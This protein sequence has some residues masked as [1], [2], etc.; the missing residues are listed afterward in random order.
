[1]LESLYI[2]VFCLA[3]QCFLTKYNFSEGKKKKKIW[4]V[5]SVHAQRYQSKVI[6]KTIQPVTQC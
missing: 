5:C 4:C 6:Q 1:M 2:S 3:C